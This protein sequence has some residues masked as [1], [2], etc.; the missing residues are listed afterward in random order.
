MWLSPV[1]FI[2]RCTRVGVLRGRGF[3]KSAGA[4]I[5]RE[6]RVRVSTN[7][8][9]RDFDL[10]APNVHDV[11][12]LEIMT[13][14]ASH[15]SEGLSWPLTPLWRQRGQQMMVQLWWWRRANLVVLAME[16]GGRWSPETA[17]FLRLLT[18]A[19]VRDECTFLRKSVDQ[20]WRL[21]WTG[22]L[23]CSVARAFVNSLLLQR[24]NGEVDDETRAL[25]CP[26]T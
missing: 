6:T 11:G 21:C 7:V 26:C 14:K 17:A 19:R 3:V 16:V 25:P 1:T 5:C 2:V 10:A 23:T 15:C 13:A 24:D 4:R 9:V 12:R 22:M 20:T 18:A 8:F